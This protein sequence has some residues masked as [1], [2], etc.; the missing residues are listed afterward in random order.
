MLPRVKV[1][2]LI[3]AVF[4]AVA[5]AADGLVAYGYQVL[6]IGEQ[7]ALEGEQF[8]PFGLGP[9]Y[10]LLGGIITRAEGPDLWL[11]G[12]EGQGTTFM[13]Y[14]PAAPGHSV[15]GWVSAIRRAESRTQVTTRGRAS[16]GRSPG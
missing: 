4:E 11:V 8:G 12:P 14:A 5:L 3:T 6:L 16:S 9:R 7:R 15:R 10:A 2:N 1:D 13:G